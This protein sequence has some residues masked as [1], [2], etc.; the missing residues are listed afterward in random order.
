MSVDLTQGDLQSIASTQSF[1]HK[2]SGRIY[3]RMS[4]GKW[5]ATLEEVVIYIGLGG[6]V[7]VRPK[8]EFYDRFEE[9][10]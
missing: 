7:W 4:E 2:K 5:E 3:V 8:D 6:Q 9:V 1:R 10:Q